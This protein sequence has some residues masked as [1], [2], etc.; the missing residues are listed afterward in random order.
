MPSDFERSSGSFGRALGQQGVHVPGADARQVARREAR[1]RRHRRPEVW[2]ARD[3]RD[4]LALDEVERLAGL[5]R[6][7][8][9]ELCADVHRGEEREAESAHP[10]ERHRRVDA[11]AREE[12]A[13]AVQVVRVAQ[14]RAVRVDGALRV[15]RRAR[16]VD[17]DQRV[18]GA[19]LALRLCEQGVVDRRGRVDERFERRRAARGPGPLAAVALP[20]T[21][22]T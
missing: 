2:P 12:V 17:K 4:A 1:V 20:D 18:G 13:E 11:V 3:H 7:L 5:E 21:H 9:E 19:H 22:L 15:R 8:A 6:I 10:E 16:A 14:H